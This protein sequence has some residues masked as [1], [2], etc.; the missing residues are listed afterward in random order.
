V[1]RA[2]AIVYALLENDSLDSLEGE[3][4]ETPLKFDTQWP[5]KPSWHPG[6]RS[7]RQSMNRNL[8]N[9]SFGRTDNYS[10]RDRNW[11]MANHGYDARMKKYQR[12]LNKHGQVM[13]GE[14][15]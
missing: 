7:A 9:R 2:Q 8:R 14:G 3:R 11:P 15:I 6:H 1:T 5:H 4:R 12:K 13:P 10:L